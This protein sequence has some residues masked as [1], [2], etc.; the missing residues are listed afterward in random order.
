MQRGRGMYDT[1]AENCENRGGIAALIADEA[2]TTGTLHGAVL[3][4]NNRITIPVLSVS[5]DD[6]KRLLQ[7]TQLITINYIAPAHR[8]VHG[9]SMAAPHVSAVAAN[10]WAARRQCTNAQIRQALQ[11]TALDLGPVGYDIRHGHGFIQATAAYFYLLNLPEPCGT[12]GGPHVP[13]IR[14][15]VGVG[16]IFSGGSIPGITTNSVGNGGGT[17][18]ITMED[19]TRILSG[20]V[21]P[22]IHQ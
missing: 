10:I 21:K 9:T 22:R 19:A 8:S 1:I 12:P 20:N 3:S 7:E 16:N 5:Y 4:M 15:V 14:P 6:G 18:N 17:G 11:E 13:T 2:G